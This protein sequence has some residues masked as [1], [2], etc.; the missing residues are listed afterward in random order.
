[1]V[2]DEREPRGRV[3]EQRV[4]GAVARTADHTQV[5]IAGADDIAIGE[6][7]VRFECFRGVGDVSPERVGGVQ[8][9]VRDAVSAHQL[10]REKPVGVHVLEIPGAVFGSGVENRDLS[11]RTALD[12]CR[13]ADVVMVVVGADHEFDGLEADSA[14]AQAL[15]E[16]RERLLAARAGIDQRQGRPVE[17]P[18]VDGPDVR[19]RDHDRRVRGHGAEGGRL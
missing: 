11:A 1:M 4:G 17:Q 2:A 14:G 19:E 7:D 16:C 13:E 9:L 10:E 12:R 8:Q 5:A 6:P 15:F 18:R 3:H